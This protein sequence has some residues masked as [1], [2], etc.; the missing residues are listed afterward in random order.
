MIF[1]LELILV[2]QV[3]KNSQLGL[4]FQIYFG[5]RGKGLSSNTVFPGGDM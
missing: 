4:T 3:V 2:F 1:F 5:S